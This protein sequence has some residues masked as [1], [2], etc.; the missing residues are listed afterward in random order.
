MDGDAED[1]AEAVFC[2]VNEGPASELGSAEE[3]AEHRIEDKHLEEEGFPFGKPFFGV[4]EEVGDEGERRNHDEKGD[5][6]LAGGDSQETGDD[7]NDGADEDWDEHP[8]ESS[9]TAGRANGDASNADTGNDGS[10]DFADGEVG[11][12]VDFAVC[13]DVFLDAGEEFAEVGPD[14]VAKVDG[15]RTDDETEIDKDDSDNE[16]REDAFDA[17]VVEAE[18]GELGIDDN[19]EEDDEDDV[20]DATGVLP[21][22]VNWRVGFHAKR[23]N[24]RKAIYDIVDSIDEFSDDAGGRADNPGESADLVFTSGW[25]VGVIGV[26]V[27]GV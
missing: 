27:V 14:D 24:D 16:A 19:E 13:D 7:G 9:A 12:F 26:R 8:E 17:V 4:G 10:D 21:D 5:K 2:R 22:E 15:E 6:S 18:A 20:S 25:L 11:D 1:E 23:R 3:E